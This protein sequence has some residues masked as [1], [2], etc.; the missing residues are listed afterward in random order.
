MAVSAKMVMLPVPGSNL[1]SRRCPRHRYDKNS[2]R[3]A[4]LHF[5]YDDDLGGA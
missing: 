2:F 1:D 3:K 4:T 5:P